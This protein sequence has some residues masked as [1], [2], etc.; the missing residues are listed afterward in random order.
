MASLQQSLSSTNRNTCTIGTRA[1]PWAR[2]VMSACLDATRQSANP[3]VSQH[4]PVCLQ[5]AKACCRCPYSL[6]LTGSTSTAGAA[7]VLRA[8]TGWRLQKHCGR[9]ACIHLPSRRR[10]YDEQ[11]DEAVEEAGRIMWHMWCMTYHVLSRIGMI[12]D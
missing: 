8:A 2:M 11:R 5:L 6:H 3:L 9:G 10:H 12:C 1:T 4:Q 7:E